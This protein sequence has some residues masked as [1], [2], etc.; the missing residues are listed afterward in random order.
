MRATPIIDLSS[1][2]SPEGCF[3]SISGV[4]SCHSTFAAAVDNANVKNYG[5]VAI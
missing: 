1:L 4:W 3:R 2:W 5:G